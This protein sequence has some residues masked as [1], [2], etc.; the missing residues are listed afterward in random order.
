MQ[1]H[2]V[3][4]RQNTSRGDMSICGASL[5]QGEGS[6]RR[7]VELEA[8]TGRNYQNETLAKTVF[9]LVVLSGLSTMVCA[10]TSTY[11]IDYVRKASDSNVDWRR[12]AFDLDHMGCSFP[13][14]PRTRG[15]LQ[16]HRQSNLT[17]LN[18]K[19]DYVQRC[20]PG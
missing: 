3:T 10:S 8:E 9:V 19:S 7:N 13:A 20:S 6:V 16:C 4:G 12:A 14:T 1:S 2:E 18:P 5:D 17:I 11:P 15:K